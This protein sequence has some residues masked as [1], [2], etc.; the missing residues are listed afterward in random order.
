MNK[1]FLNKILSG[2]SDN[3]IRFSNLRKLLITLNFIERR[4]SSNQNSIC[5]KKS[6]TFLVYSNL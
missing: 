6:P 2:T 5:A 4:L 3:N 1:K